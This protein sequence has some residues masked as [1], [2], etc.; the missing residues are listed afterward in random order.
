MDFFLDSNVII[1]YVFYQAD[2]WGIPSKNV[3][4]RAEKKYSGHTVEIECFDLQRG[5]CTTVRRE[6]SS[7]FF[8]AVANIEEN[9]SIDFLLYDA[10]LGNWKIINIL[11]NILEGFQG[12]LISLKE[13]LREYQRRFEIESKT[14]QKNVKTLVTFSYRTQR[15]KD[16]HTALGKI[17]QNINDIEVILDAHELAHLHSELILITGDHKDILKNKPDILPLVKISDIKNL[18]EY[19]T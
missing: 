6:I 11:K 5:K 10:E 3:I 18:R 8:K 14:R 13:D 1:G 12:D 17:I 19:T 4:K 7:E 15:Y 9:Q 16:I 2:Y